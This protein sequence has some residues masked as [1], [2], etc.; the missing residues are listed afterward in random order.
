MVLSH[1]DILK[2]YIQK[3]C[4]SIEKESNI[5][6]THFFENYFLERLDMKKVREK[7]T[8]LYNEMIQNLEASKTTTES[9]KDMYTYIINAEKKNT[10]AEWKKENNTEEEEKAS[11]IEYFV[12][13]E[14]PETEAYY[15][16]R[17]TFF[18]IIND[19]NS[20]RN[21]RKYLKNAKHILFRILQKHELK[22]L[23][24]KIKDFERKSKK[25]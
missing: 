3:L 2:V 13:P 10:W 8:H 21:H 19:D 23:R 15:E 17:K 14:T 16:N 20:R 9:Y 12:D 6:P 22:H 24:E 7:I 1:T 11:E 4:T 25:I 18:D 5:N